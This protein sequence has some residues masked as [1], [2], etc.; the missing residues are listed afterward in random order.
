MESSET[1]KKEKRYTKIT[2]AIIWG[3]IISTVATLVT[4]L[5]VCPILSTPRTISLFAS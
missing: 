3:I 4:N 1:G 2:N 5:F